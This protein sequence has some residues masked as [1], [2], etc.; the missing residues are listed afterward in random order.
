MQTSKKSRKRKVW[1]WI[2]ISVVVLVVAATFFLNPMRRPT[3]AAFQSYTVTRGNVE[4]TITG[5]GTLQAND[6]ENIDLPDGILVSQALVKAGDVIH[7]GDTLATLD[8]ESLVDRAAYL[9]DELTTLDK[10]ISSRETLQYIY[11]PVE[12]RIKYLPVS[13]GDDVVGTIGEQGVLAIIST[14]GLMKIEVTTEQELALNAEV[15]VKWSDISKTG[16]IARKTA[17]GY[18]VTLTDNGTPYKETAQVYSGDTLIGEGTI[19]I[20]APITVYGNNGTIKKVHYSENASVSAGNTLFTLKDAM[21]TNSYRLALV[22]RNEMAEQFQAV[23]LYMNNPQIIVTTDGLVSEVLISD[24][25]KTGS[26]NSTGTSAQSVS[27]GVMGENTG[28]SAQSTVSAGTTAGSGFSTAF[29]IH[30]GGAVKMFINVDE[31]DINSVVLNQEVTIT[32]DAFAGESYKAKV[33]H[34]SKLGTASGNITTYPVELSLEYNERFLEGM[35][36]SAVIMV[37]RAENVLFIPIAAIYED[38]T[39]TYV[40]TVSGETRTRVDITTGISDGVN[41]E[42]T[43]GLS[44]NDVIQYIDTSSSSAEATGGFGSMGGGGNPFG[45]GRQ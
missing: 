24:N 10:N 33:T 29:T 32:L 15:T 27:G 4:S 5:S 9:S 22:E 6:V 45:G 17:S 2:L 44:E 35:N 14:D 20:N 28:A 34:I 31:L 18:I 42:V 39:G 26:G 21:E 11:A 12:G 30:T 19:M 13:E 38:T 25:T 23:L 3:T 40:Y 1:P 36:G 7:K 16:K 41:A 43:S 37:E 8:Y